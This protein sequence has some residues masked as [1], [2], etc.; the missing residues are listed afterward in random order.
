[1]VWVLGKVE[2]K[3][4]KKSAHHEKGEQIISFSTTGHINAHG[5]ESIVPLGTDCGSLECRGDGEGSIQW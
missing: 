4:C 3:T 1:M 2:V 5:K